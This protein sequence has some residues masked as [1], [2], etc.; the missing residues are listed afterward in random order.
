MEKNSILTKNEF[1]ANRVAA[2]VMLGTI[3][4]VALVFVLDAL[5]I[6]VAPLDTMS[7]AL[8]IATVLLI[9]PSFIVFILKLE[10][11][12]IKYVTVAAAT[13]MVAS[14]NMFLSFHVILLYVYS[15]AI[16]SLFFSRRL[17][18][19]AVLLSLVA[20]S[21]SSMLSLHVN[22]LV[23]KNLPNTHDMLLYG[24]GP[25]SIELVALTL[26]F[27]LLSKRTRKMLNN[28]MGAE[29]QK[30]LLD[31]TLSITQKANE[32]SVVLADSSS[33]LSQVTEHTTKSNEQIAENTSR[34]AT[35]S[36]NTITLVN[37]AVNA[38]TNISSSLNK[39]AQ[40][41][42]LIANVSLNLE[43]L[44]KTNGT[45]ME[46]AANQ[47]HA[48][49]D[50]TAESKEIIFRLGE[51]SNEIGK[52]VEVIS[53]I[54]SQTNLLALNA[55]IESARAGEQGKGF[56]VVAEEIRQLAEQSQ[57]ATRHIDT[58]MKEVLEDTKKAV[59]AMDKDSKTVSNG[60]EVINE[61]VRSFEKV[62]VAS[63]EMDRK[64]QGVNSVTAEVA[65]DSEKV[66]NYVQSIR[67]INLKN[68]SEIQ[69]IAAAT[70][71]Q[72]AAMQEVTAS[73]DGIDRISHE[74]LDVVKG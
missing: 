57:K 47:M 63:R 68:L 46:D 25:R 41:T 58:L 17:S 42:Q 1:E 21:I 73:V 62:S 34:I 4:F 26:I 24:I 32:V 8:A 60:I 45:I 64:V 35:G 29:E 48:I 19:F 7:I 51:R 3:L 30:N 33:Q 70:E 15:I 53:S 49:N 12:W 14:L 71:Q 72:L 5:K 38:V 28:V 39:I 23:D 66:V 16:A 65:G 13:L 54:S 56:A 2:K 37:D 43:E 18:W 40:E 55:A 11:W 10:G 50:T 52:I 69:N 74:L 22:G 9:I 67:D 44:T 6:F 27:I 20:I 61:A 59:D 31:K 36:E